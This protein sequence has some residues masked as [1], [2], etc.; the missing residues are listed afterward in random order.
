MRSR[1]VSLRCCCA[2]GVSKT[3]ASAPDGFRVNNLTI[4][5]LRAGACRHVRRRGDS[6]GR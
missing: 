1:A 4:A 5:A 3:G 6:A 2:V